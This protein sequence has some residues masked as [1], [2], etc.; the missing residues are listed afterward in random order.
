MATAL[1]RAPI[2]GIQFKIVHPPLFAHRAKDVFK[3]LLHFRVRAVQ[4]I[5]RAIAPTAKRDRAGI[6]R[7][8]VG[9]L[10]KP[11]RMLAQHTRILL[12]DKGR[13]PNR[14]LKPFCANIGNGL[15]DVAILWIR[16][17]PIA[18][19]GLIPIIQLNEFQ[20][21]HL[22]LKNIQIV[23]DNFI[24]HIH[25]V[26]IPRA[27]PRRHRTHLT[28]RMIAIDPLGQFIKQVALALTAQHNKLFERPT[29]PRLQH[30]SFGIHRDQQLLRIKTDSTDKTLARREA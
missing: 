30:Q 17:K 13:H 25:T 1:E 27:P 9:I 3:M 20:L 14:R 11:I 8:A 15:L 18:E 23:A 2:V 5:P 24:R 4:G 10:H 22:L 26:A 7:L 28:W 19:K 21:G 12:R 29:L 6:E 16:V